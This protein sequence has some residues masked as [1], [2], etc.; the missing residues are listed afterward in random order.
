MYMSREQRG[1]HPIF[2]SKR[3]FWGKAAHSSTAVQGLWGRAKMRAHS[4]WGVWSTTIWLRDGKKKPTSDWRCGDVECCLRKKLMFKKHPNHR[5]GKEA[6]TTRNGCTINGGGGRIIMTTSNYKPRCWCSPIKNPAETNSVHMSSLKCM[7][8]RSLQFVWRKQPSIPL[9]P[10]GTNPRVPQL[11]HCKN[12][13]L[14]FLSFPL[15]LLK[16]VSGISKKGH[17][18]FG[19]NFA[20]QELKTSCVKPQHI[21]QAWAIKN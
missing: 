16:A 15:F 17:V 21:L 9:C 5:L 4:K 2:H 8:C 10:D 3:M 6:E 1:F 19:L 14:F 12:H 20:L 11:D 18:V 7:K 13:P